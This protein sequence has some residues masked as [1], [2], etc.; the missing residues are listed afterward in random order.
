M[1]RIIYISILILL[2]LSFTAFSQ[3]FDYHRDFEKIRS[4][5]KDSSSSLYYPKLLQRFQKNES[6]LVNAELLA[7]QIGFTS[8]ENYTPYKTIKEE[9]RILKLVQEKKY[10]EALEVCDRLLITNPL[11]LTALINKEIIYQLCSMSNCP[12]RGPST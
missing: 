9:K 5:N 4:L 12:S 6:T 1:I 11:S 8:S 3:D 10:K 2:S 7:L